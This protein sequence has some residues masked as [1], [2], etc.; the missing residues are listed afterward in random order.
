MCIDYNSS[1]IA[2][3]MAIEV[4]RKIALCFPMNWRIAKWGALKY[5]PKEYVFDP[6]FFCFFL[7]KKLDFK[8]EVA[9]E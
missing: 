2:S 1:T 4:G 6:L 9:L 8:K 7:L 3:F 5:W